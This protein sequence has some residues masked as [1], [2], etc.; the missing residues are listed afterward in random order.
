MKRVFVIGNGESRLQVPLVR[1][2]PIG[3]LYGCNALYRDFAPDVLVVID[4]HM[5]EEVI[6]SGYSVAHRCYFANDHRAERIPSHCLVGEFGKTQYCGPTAI[7]LA[8]EN[9][10]PDEVYLVGFDII[11][12]KW[13]NVYSGTS[14]Y[15]DHRE[16]GRQL[17]AAGKLVVHNAPTLQQLLDIFRDNQA[18][19]FFK[20]M[21]PQGFQYATWEGQKNLTYLTGERF[22]SRFGLQIGKCEL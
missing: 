22:Q 15:Q 11:D 13:S 17:V 14:G 12:R 19:R 5:V 6:A 1:L 2:R 8:I 10:S 3:K 9:E 20:V 7:R 18:R 16:R 4:Q 21:E